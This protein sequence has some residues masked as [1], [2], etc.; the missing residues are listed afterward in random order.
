MLELVIYNKAVATFGISDKKSTKKKVCDRRIRK[1]T[2]VRKQIKS[3]AS[4]IK[5]CPDGD[6]K[7]G[8]IFVLD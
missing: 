1:L 4:Q 6:I 2:E 8:L 3:L 5:E 7:D